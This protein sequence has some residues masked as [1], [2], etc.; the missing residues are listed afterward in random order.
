MWYSRKQA[1]VARSSIEFEYRDLA[2]TTTEIMWIKHL[3]HDLCISLPNV[4]I[5]W[6]YN[7]ISTAVAAN[8]VLHLHTKHVKLDMHFI[9]EKVYANELLVQHIFS[10]V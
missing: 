4:P 3:L 1:V 8:H 9:C 5:I 6:Y 7:R 10:T 2:T